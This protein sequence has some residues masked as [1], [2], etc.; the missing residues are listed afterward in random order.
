M[1]SIIFEPKFQS[2]AVTYNYMVNFCAQAYAAPAYLT[3]DH[4]HI[5]LLL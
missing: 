3:K 5:N 1:K 2:L 4:A